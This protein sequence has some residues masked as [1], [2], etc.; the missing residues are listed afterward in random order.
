MILRSQNQTAFAKFH[1][2]RKMPNGNGT[3]KRISCE[4]N[5]LFAASFESR[6]HKEDA[7]KNYDFFQKLCANRCA[8]SSLSGALYLLFAPDCAAPNSSPTQPVAAQGDA[9]AQETKNHDGITNCRAGGEAEPHHDAHRGATSRARCIRRCA[10][11]VSPRR[12]RCPACAS[13]PSASGL[14]S[15]RP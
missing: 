13:R 1:F 8:G 10:F 2:Q 14:R 15:L 7:A 6:K 11:V 9:A 5:N 4:L 12:R 3:P